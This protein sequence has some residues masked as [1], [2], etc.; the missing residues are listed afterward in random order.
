MHLFIKSELNTCVIFYE[1]HCMICMQKKKLYP[2]ERERERERERDR[3]GREEEGESLCGMEAKAPRSNARANMEATPWLAIG[4]LC[5]C[6]C[7]IAG[8]RRLSSSL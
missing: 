3:E 2:I 1:T 4:R 5:L 7:V 8:P 6:V